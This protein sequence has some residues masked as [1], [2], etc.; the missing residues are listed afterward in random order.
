MFHMSTFAAVKVLKL[1]PRY[2]NAS[3]P[4]PPVS[5]LSESTMN[6][7]EPTPINAPNVT[8]P[9]NSESSEVN[10]AETIIPTM[11]C[12]QHTNEPNFMWG[13]VD[14]T[15]FSKAINSAYYQAI[16]WRHNLFQVPWGKVGTSFVTELASLFR[17]YGES[18]A[19][20]SVAL[21]AAMVMPILLL[22]KPHA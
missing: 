21:R 17:S 22:Q 15:S 2:P 12:C 13:T 20:E 9:N 11:P 18:T 3:S 1:N 10:T 8:I 4:G 7:Q 14:G 5:I 16:H 6:T 19:L